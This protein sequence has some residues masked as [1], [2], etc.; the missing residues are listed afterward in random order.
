MVIEYE[1]YCL[2]VE[3]WQEIFFK[4]FACWIRGGAIT[5]TKTLAHTAEDATAKAKDCID[6]WLHEGDGN[7]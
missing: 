1:G 3:P 6:S 5:I 2:E 4:G 7:G